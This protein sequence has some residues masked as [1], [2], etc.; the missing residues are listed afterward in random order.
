MKIRLQK[1]AIHIG[2]RRIHGSLLIP[3]SAMPGVLFVHGWG[4][5]Q[6]QDLGRARAAVELGCVCLTFDLRGHKE[7]AAERETVTRGDNLD[8]LLAAYDLF[9]GER[10]VDNSHIAVVG[11]SYGAYL[12]AILT[13]LRPVRWLAMLA[14]ALYKDEGWELPKRALNRDPDL[15]VFRQGQVSPAQS[16]ALRACAEFAGDA[17]I[18][19][20]ENDERIP[21]S[22]IANYVSAFAKP[23]SLTSR[24]IHGADHA[25][26]KKD[27]QAAYT[28]I[29]IK[30]LTEM[31]TGARGQAVPSRTPGA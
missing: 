3:Q 29:L 10:N 21:H 27:C 13:S 14:P 31:V 7:T 28:S 9:A 12:A 22:I 4:G 30:W 8:D 11:Y 5:S 20:A 6:D 24:M 15:Q 23:H 19:E 1:R 26:S 16:R 25:L 18:V 2:N 17:L